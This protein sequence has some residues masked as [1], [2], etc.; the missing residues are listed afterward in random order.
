VGPGG[1]SYTLAHQPRY[2]AD[3]L[4]TLKLAILQGTGMSFLPN[5]MCH[6]ELESGRLALVLPGWAPAQGVFHA[7]YPS[8]R[9]MVPAV[10]RFLDFLGEHI[11]GEGCPK[12]QLPQP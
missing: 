2:V 6:E 11:N 7:V 8:R 9:G 5:Y 3:D 1:A 10:R 12:T 4:L